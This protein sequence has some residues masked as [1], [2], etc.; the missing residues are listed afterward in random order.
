VYE[1]PW[2]IFRLLDASGLTAQSETRFSVAISA[3]GNNARLLLDA[4]SIRNPFVAPSLARF[5]CGD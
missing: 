5:R 3:G 1:G 4:S 2:A